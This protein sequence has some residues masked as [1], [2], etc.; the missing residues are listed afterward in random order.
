MGAAGE[1]GRSLVRAGGL[2]AIRYIRV[3]VFWKEAQ[4]PLPFLLFI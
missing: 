2:S 4:A 1:G 3:R